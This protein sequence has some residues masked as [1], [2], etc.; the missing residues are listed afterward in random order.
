MS[1]LITKVKKNDSSTDKLHRQLI[2]WIR[3]KDTESLIDALETNTIDINFMD[4]VGQTLLNWASA[5]GTAEMVEYLAARGG[6]INKGQRSSSLHYAACF[7]R[8]NI[9]KILLHHGANPD[10]RDEEGKTPL[11]KARERGEESHRECVQILQSPSDYLNCH[12]AS[13]LSNLNEYE[14]NSNESLNVSS[15]GQN[16]EL[17]GDKNMPKNNDE[18][19]VEEEEEAETEDHEEEGEEIEQ[20]RLQESSR[21][22]EEEKGKMP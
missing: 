4:D 3:V 7:G 12:L 20:N 8:A 11:D 2:E 19:E 16:E 9:V 18:Q 17:S 10:L 21:N 22:I 1:S 14:N 15:S 13:S 5:F 6:D